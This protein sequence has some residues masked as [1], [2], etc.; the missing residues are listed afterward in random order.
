MIHPLIICSIK[1]FIWY[2]GE[3]N[4]GDGSKYTALNSA[5]IQSWRAAF[6]QS[7]LPFYFVQMTPYNWKKDQ[8]F[9]DNYAYF[10]EAQER[11]LD[12][13]P[14]TGMIVTMDNNEV[15]RIHPRNKAEFGRRLAL[16]ALNKTYH[17]AEVVCTGPTLQNFVIEGDKIITDWNTGDSSTVL[18]T[19]DGDKPKHFYVSGSDKV[20]YQADAEIIDHQIWLTCEEVT[21]PVAVRYA[22]L[23]YPVTNLCNEQGLPA[24]PFR[25]DEW[26]EV[27]YHADGQ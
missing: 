10:R 16:V 1:G 20:F 15:T 11:I 23:N 13:V 14:N 25:T 6:N 27:S 7:K 24:L 4:A 3:S 2:Q 26:E 8:F 17:H 19:S 5:M 12:I 21:D 9:V 18:T 22:F